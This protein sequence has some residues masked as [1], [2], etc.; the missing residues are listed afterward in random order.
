MF[1]DHCREKKGFYYGR[2]NGVVD[3]N[4]RLEKCIKVDSLR[5]GL[6]QQKDGMDL[7][8]EKRS[9]YYGRRNGV[10]DRNARLENIKVDSLRR[11]KGVSQF[12]SPD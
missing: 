12:F 1:H 10:V 4:A 6:K 5:R 8:M 7:I 9:F 3:R 2:R 11:G